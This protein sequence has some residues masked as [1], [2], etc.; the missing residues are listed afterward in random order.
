MPSPS[1]T[2]KPQHK[3]HVKLSKQCKE[4]ENPYST[5]TRYNMA[6]TNT[7]LYGGAIT[8]DL[9]SNFADAS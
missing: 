5:T 8:L 2:S 1:P 4:S 3:N 6:F 7:P 9:P